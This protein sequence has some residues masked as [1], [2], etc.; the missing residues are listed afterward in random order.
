MAVRARSLSTTF[1]LSLTLALAGPGRGTA[2]LRADEPI[3]EHAPLPPPA[4]VASILPVERRLDPIGS[5][6]TAARPAVS[7]EMAVGG[8]PPPA[9]LQAP[10]GGLGVL[11]LV[12]AFPDYPVIS[13]DRIQHFLERFTGVRRD[14]VGRWLDRS[15]R[16]LGMVRRTLRLNGL[17]E[18]LAFTAMIESGF[19][20]FA[21]SRA[22]AKGLWQFMARTAR[23]YGLRVDQWVDERLDPEKSTMAAAAYLRDLYN[24][25]GSWFLAQAAYNAG[26]TQVARAIKLGRT[27][28]FWELARSRHLHDE[29]K[30]FVPAIQAVTLIGRDPDRY[31]FEITE[32]PAPRFQTLRVP[33]ATDL[34]RLARGAALSLEMLQGLNPE[35]WRRMT[36]PTGFYELK[37]PEGSVERVRLALV[38]A[39]V[40]PPARGRALRAGG[41]HVVRPNETLGAIAK[42]YGVRVGELARWNRLGRQGVIWP[43]DRIRITSGPVPARNLEEG[44]FR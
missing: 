35:L 34:G 28:D 21:V 16:Y 24:Q 18:D 11:P 17:P 30:D 6:A 31:G 27:N 44:G 42:K 22:G 5:R 3:V 29:T 32:Y 8:P 7:L 1:A 41:V 20:P 13:N 25:F 9:V 37:V 14:V 10:P 4:S 43:G 15:S 38:S 36:P 40:T 12:P 39:R 23:T 19:N 33:P 26:E 2:E